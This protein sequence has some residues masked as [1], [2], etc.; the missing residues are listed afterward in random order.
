MEKEHS[1]LV[2]MTWT[3][4]KGEGTKNYRAFDRDHILQVQGKADIAG[5][6]DPSFRGSPDR[7]N[8]E[9]L[10]VCSISSCHMLWYLHLCSV[11]NIVVTAYRDEARGT[12][13]EDADGS[14]R[15]R[16]VEL[17]PAITL[18]DEA[19]IGKA[20]QL[21][22]E[23]HRFCFIANSVNFPIKHRPVFTVQTGSTASR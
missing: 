15:F 7:Y 1:Y 23:A 3:G 11:N 22:E 20:T 6:S 17:N 2:S 8:P 21:H 12:M 10:L 13:I 19:M 5:S 9:E 16:E 14:G 18:T 4:N